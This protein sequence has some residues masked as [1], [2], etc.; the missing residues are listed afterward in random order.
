[1]LGHAGDLHAALSLGT[2]DGAHV[3][4]RRKAF[5]LGGPVVH[6][7]RRAH[8]E[9]GLGIPRLHA[10]QDMRDHLQR[11]AQAHVV[12]QDAA[13]PQVLERAEP[14]VAVD[15]IAAQCGLERGG[16][17]KVHLAER[18]QAL[19][20]A[21]ER[22]VA[23]GFKHG[24]AREHAIDK[25]GARRG[26]RHAVEQV[27]GI[28][29][30]VLG[31]A[32][33]GSGALVQAHDVAGRQARE[34]L[35]ALVRVQIDGK[36]GRRKTARAQLDVEQV[37]LDGGAHREPGRRAHRDLAQ[38]V[39]EHDLAQLGQGRQALGQQVE[40]ALVVAL[41][42]RQAA[43]VKVEIQGRRV[44]NAKLCYLVARR[45]TRALFFEGA[46]R[47]SQAKEICRPA[48]VGNRNLAGHET[49]VDADRYGKTRLGRHGVKYGGSG[50]VSVVA[51]HGQCHTAEFAHLLGGDMDRRATGQQTRQKR[52]GMLGKRRIGAARAVRVDQIGN[53]ARGKAVRIGGQAQ[54]VAATSRRRN[55][56]GEERRLFC[57]GLVL[58]HRQQLNRYLVGTMRRRSPRPGGLK[59][60]GPATQQVQ[61]VY[62]VMLGQ[63]QLALG[64]KAAAGKVV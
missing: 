17:R 44:H 33:R 4:R 2:H 42:K 16:H 61:H 26:K 38:T 8:H 23:I 9:R 3:E 22:G 52:C 54:I 46:A 34:R 45:H 28:D 64:D 37:A 35:V 39:A 31:E 21:A 11:F 15:L 27:D 48:T 6:K 36:V 30:Q 10:R 47:S 60:N 43:L 14:L 55:L 59:G 1:M 63:R 40:Q 62:D 50:E 49:V 57:R 32:K 58:P 25:Q 24:R 20:G 41:L 19:D 51:Q 29:A 56:G 18:I 7:R 53:V 12:G 13:E 5:Q